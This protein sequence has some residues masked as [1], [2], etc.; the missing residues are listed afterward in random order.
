MNGIDTMK[1]SILSILSI[2]SKCS[3]ADPV[4]P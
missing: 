3:V 4:Q 1:I 2:L